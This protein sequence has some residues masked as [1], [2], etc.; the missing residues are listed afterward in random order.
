MKKYLLL[1]ALLSF[2]I[3]FYS[4][5]EDLPRYLTQEEVEYARSVDYQYPTDRGIT[6]PPPYA[7][8]RTAAEW[9][10]VQA[11]TV[12]WT[13]YPVIL[14]QIVAAAK[15]EVEV[16]IFSENV[17]STESYLTS[18]NAGGPAMNLTN[19]TVLDEQINS[20]WIRDYGANTCYGSEVGDLF[21]VDWIY[22]RPRPDDD[23]IPD[24]LASHMGLDLY[25]TTTAPNDLMNTGGNFMSDGFGTAFASELILDENQGGSAGWTNYPNHNISEIDGIMDD[26]MGISPYI[27]MPTLPYDG[28]HHIDMHMKLL[29]EETLLVSEYPD[30]VADGPTIESNINYVLNNFTTKWGTPFNVINI[31]APPQQSNGNYPDDNGWYLTYANAIFINNTILLPTYYEPWDAQ[32]I[33]IWEDALPGYNIVG[34]DCDNSGSAIIAAGGAIH[35][36]THT[37]GVADPMLISYKCID[38]TNDDVNDHSLTAYINH[39]SGIASASLFWKTNLVDPYTEI[40]MTNIG[41]NDWN[42]SIPA[43]AYGTTVYYYVEGTANSGKVQT[44][45]MPAPE[46]YKSFQIINVVFGCTNPV[47]C[48]YDPTATSDDGT[49][50][51]PDGCTDS[52]ACNYNPGAQCDDGSCVIGALQ[53]LTISTDC[54][55]NETTWTITDGGGATVLSGGSYAD[56]NTFIEDVCL[57]DGCYDFNIF[58]SFGDGL[59]GSAS[60]G[61]DVDGD[62]DMVDQDGNLLFEMAA[63]NFGSSETH[64]FCV[65]TSTNGCTNPAACNYNPDATTDDGSCQLP[66]GCTDSGACNYSGAAL[67]DDG[68]CEFI[69]CQGCTD[70]GACNYDPTSTIN[71]GSCEYLTCAGCTNA[72]ACN[73]DPAATIDDGSCQNPD[74]CT[75]PGACNYNPAALCDAGTCEYVTCQGC[76]DNAACNYDGSATQDDGSCTYSLT[77][78]VDADADGYGNVAVPVNLCNPQIGFVLDNTDCDDTSNL[79]H[80]GA[81]GTAEGIDN[82][83]NGIIDPEEE[84][85]SCVGDFNLDGIINAGDLLQFLAEF[86]CAFDCTVDLTG[87]GIVNAADLLVFLGVFGSVC[88]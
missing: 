72:L 88:P 16:I 15:E 66:D 51:L 65:D 19:V 58:D 11:V 41:G 81:A 80:P 46:G 20:V 85:T 21:L 49:C 33:Q 83:C 61:C 7:N 29:D 35:C 60:N 31:P 23:V 52:N 12:S 76:T 32:A 56:E 57:A 27:K 50:I 55:G 47:A 84:L 36:I 42:A 14:K 59:N 10:E 74:G 26:F 40:A 25:S 38:D 79:V 62:Y 64:A 86:G 4:Q 77:Y 71:D 9:E 17:S 34:I 70:L 67:C 45:P 37:V 5:L 18:S 68:S 30:G 28:I 6:D 2:S 78:Y 75:D 43:Q 63:P 39:Q 44:K 22:N 24:A 69:T 87:D 48:N 13:S 8:I 73:Y 54:W 53:T 82:N 1:G 3:A